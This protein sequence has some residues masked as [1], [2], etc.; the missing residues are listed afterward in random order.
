MP[1][2]THTITIKRRDT[3]PGDLLFE[4]TATDGSD[5]G[6]LTATD[7]FRVKPGDKIRWTSD[8]GNFGLLFKGDAPFNGGVVSLGGVKGEFTSAR[9][10][11][12]L[13]GTPTHPVV[14]SFEYA[15]TVIE[16]GAASTIDPLMEISD[17]AGGTK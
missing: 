12:K 17:S 13:G 15:A 10:A 7:P 6:D 11:K 8:L 2:V 1:S 9:V 5:L 16:D 4:H 3:P 14:V